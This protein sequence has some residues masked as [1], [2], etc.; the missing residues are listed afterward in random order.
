MAQMK[1]ATSTITVPHLFSLISAC[2]A[3]RRTYII[4]FQVPRNTSK[5]SI[6]SQTFNN[7]FDQ[8]LRIIIKY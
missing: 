2:S 6:N 4:T 3:D 5:Q 1:K 7:A 8:F